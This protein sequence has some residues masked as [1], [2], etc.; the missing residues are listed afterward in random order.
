MSV[1]SR[2]RRSRLGRVRGVLAGAALVGL[3]LGVIPAYPATARP[4]LFTTVNCSRTSGY[5]YQSAHLEGFP[6]HENVAE[7][8][9][10]YRPT[11]IS[12]Y[13]TSSRTDANGS[14]T[15]L[16]DPFYEPDPFRWGLLLARDRDS[17]GNYT[18]GDEVIAKLIVDISQPCTWTRGHPK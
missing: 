4:H 6:P 18:A 15:P 8:I 1:R 5:G 9:V 14:A 12:T 13:N 11:G 10:F 2:G 16:F 7:Y 17:S 3:L